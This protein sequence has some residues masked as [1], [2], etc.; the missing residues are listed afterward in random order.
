M[1]HGYLASNQVVGGCSGVDRWLACGGDLGPVNHNQFAGV[2]AELTGFFNEPP[3]QVVTDRRCSGEKPEI[4]FVGT[5]HE[6]IVLVLLV[7]LEYH[8]RSPMGSTLRDMYM[9]NPAP[10][11]IRQP[12]R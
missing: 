9:T 7:E 12:V 5:R 10:T 1:Q 11:R 6:C 4:G 2:E 8:I 3:H